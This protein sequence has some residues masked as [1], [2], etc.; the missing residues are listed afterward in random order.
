MRGVAGRV[1]ESLPPCEFRSL[2]RSGVY[3]CDAAEGASLGP[4]EGE[5]VHRILRQLL[6]A[7]GARR[8]AELPASDR[9]G[10]A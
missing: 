6:G 4:K 2:D 10:G 9:L 7:G 1:S 5:L 8:R 3:R